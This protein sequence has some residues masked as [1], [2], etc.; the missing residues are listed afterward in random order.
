MK[1]V[2]KTPVCETNE[3][4]AETL[5]GIAISGETD[6]WHVESKDEQFYEEEDEEVGLPTFNVWE[7]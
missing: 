6:P 3:L 4:L 1:R 2:Y 5:M 7:E